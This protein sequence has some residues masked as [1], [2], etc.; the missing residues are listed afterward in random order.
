MIIAIPLL[1]KR[2]ALLTK[3]LILFVF[4]LTSQA[5]FSQT[6]QEHYWEPDFGVDISTEG[7]WSYSFGIGKRSLLGARFDGEKVEDFAVEHLQ[8]AHFT[9]Y[10]LQNGIKVGL[11]LRYRFREIF[12]DN[13]YDEL[14]FQQQASYKY[15][16]SSFEI[17]HRLRTEQRLRNVETIHRFRYDLGVSRPLSDVFELEANTE[18]LFSV[19]PQNKPALE[20]RFGIGIANTSFNNLSFNLGFEFQVED[21]NLDTTHEYFFLTGVTLEL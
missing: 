6:P 3:L 7:P 20:Q 9:Y 2:K 17:S 8:L 15:P 13:R 4:T 14:R 18:A 10:Q 21:Y 16:V 19:S 11:G 12:D 5:S 1:C